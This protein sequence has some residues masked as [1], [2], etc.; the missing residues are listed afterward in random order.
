MDAPAPAHLELELAVAVE[1]I[2]GWLRTASGPAFAFSGYVELIDLLDRA[3]RGAD[4]SEGHV[5][6]DEWG[7]T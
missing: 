7:A 2:S 4:G 5:L 6:E 1:P 3:R